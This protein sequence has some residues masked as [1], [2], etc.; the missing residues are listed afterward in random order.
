MRARH[1]HFNPRDAGAAIALDSRYGFSQADGSSVSIWEDRTNNNNDAEQSTPANQPTY[2]TNEVGGQPAVKFDASNDRLEFDRADP[3]EAW[4]V[5]ICKRT[6]ANMFQAPFMVKQLAIN[7]N[8][9]EVGLNNSAQYGPVIV[10]ANGNSTLGGIGGSLRNDQWRCLFAEWLGGGSSGASFYSVR[11][12]GSLISLSNSGSVGAANQSTLS[13]VGGTG[14][15]AAFTA[16]FGGLIAQLAIGFTRPNA[17]M[18]K[19]LEHAAAFSFKISC[20]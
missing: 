11:D 15:G 8:A 1:R 16:P 3:T 14:S 20:N 6:S 4:S 17:S 5:L 13:Y 12:D 10:V 18:R 7:R 9:F 2:E 19:R